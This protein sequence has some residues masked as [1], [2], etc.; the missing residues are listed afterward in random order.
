MKFSKILLEILV[1]I[2]KNIILAV[3]VLQ[4]KSVKSAKLRLGVGVIVW[5]GY[6]FPTGVEVQIHA[7]LMLLWS[8]MQFL[9]SENLLPPEEAAPTL[10]FVGAGQDKKPMP[11][12]SHT[13]KA[14]ELHEQS[15]VDEVPELETK[16]SFS[17]NLVAWGPRSSAPASAPQTPEA[18]T[19]KY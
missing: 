16:H 15:L 12:P 17:E 14:T 4:G 6:L 8:R 3:D 5:G 13:P 9:F 7:Q 2:I 1:Y 11:I 10:T 18:P 19:G